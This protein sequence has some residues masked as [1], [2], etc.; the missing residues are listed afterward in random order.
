[1]LVRS[2]PTVLLTMIFVLTILLPQPI[3]A[4]VAASVTVTLDYDRPLGTIQLAPGVT[5][6]QYSLD[7]WD[8]PVA[9]ARG[10]AVLSASTVYQNQHLMGWGT[11]NPEPAP[12]VY[13]W[14]S[15]D[16]RIQLMRETGATKVITLCAAPDWMK[17]GRPG[18]TDWEKLA[19]APTPEHFADFAELARQTALRYPDV[20]YFQV[21]NELKGFWNADLNRWDYEGYT[22]LYNLV[23]DALKA[24]NPAIQVGGPY[25]VMDSWG[26]RAAMSNPSDVVGPYGTLD[27]RPLDVISYWLANK[28]GADFITVDGGNTNWDK[29]SLTDPFTA[30]QKFTDIA[31]W[32]HAQ[33][34]LPIWWAEWYAWGT[35]KSDL[36]ENNAVMALALMRMAQSGVS[37]ALMWQPQGDEKGLS[38]PTGLFTKT[39]TSGGGQATSY[40][41]S[42]KAFKDYFRPGV[43]FYD[44]TVSSPALQVLATSTALLLINTTPAPLSITVNGRVI[45]LMAYEVTV[46]KPP[47]PRRYKI[48]S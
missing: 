23:Y 2:F 25:V 43:T 26:D 31:A 5:H 8:D 39:K 7:P 42:Q 48:G 28:H 29:D 24:V 18:T 37:V 47:Y 45:T 15:L 3:A 13:N 22:T 10:R 41:A 27:Q 40:Y 6:G 14:T 30:T 19:A 20:L 1:M 4:A 12:G 16:R 38:F 46:R 21:W 17:G 36:P 35:A 9:V 44:T 11:E 33:T 32:I 34:S